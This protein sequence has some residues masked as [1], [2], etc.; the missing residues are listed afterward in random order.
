MK[1]GILAL[2]L[3]LTAS[4]AWA[5]RDNDNLVSAKLQPRNEVPAVSSPASGR[6]KAVIDD[7]A[8]TIDYEFTFDGLQANILQ[9]HIHFAQPN[10]NGAIVVW[11][12]GTTANPGPAGTQPCPQSGTITGT[13]RPANI[14]TVT[15]QGIATGEFTEL[16]DAIRGGLTYVNIHTVQ[17]PGGELRGQLKTR[18]RD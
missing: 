13:I 4:S 11:I 6:F 14:L 1:K 10:V 12:C 3:L 9:S 17:S 2:A 8:Q 7:A 5:E 16:V 15:T 18:D